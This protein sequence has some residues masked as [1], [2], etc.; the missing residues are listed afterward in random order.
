MDNSNDIGIVILS[1]NIN[2]NINEITK[3]VFEIIY[4]FM[5]NPKKYKKIKDYH[6]YEG[7]YRSKWGDSI[8]LAINGRLIEFNPQFNSPMVYNN[9]LKLQDKNEFL[10]ESK[11]NFESIGET[12]KFEL[13]KKGKVVRLFWGPTPAI[14]IA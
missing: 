1:N 2:Y 11:N 4:S 14:K 6:K 5:D 7:L 12:A 3:G 8:I 10:I 13:D 9:T